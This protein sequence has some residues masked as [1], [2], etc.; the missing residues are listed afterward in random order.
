ML[1]A[2]KLWSS[3]AKL[4]VHLFHQVYWLDWWLWHSRG[5]LY[6]WDKWRGVLQ[7]LLREVRV[8]FSYS[9][10]MQMKTVSS[11]KAHT[12]A[13]PPRQ[14]VSVCIFTYF[15]TAKNAIMLSVLSDFLARLPRILFFNNSLCKGP[16]K[17]LVWSQPWSGNINFI[18][19][20]S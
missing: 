16:I 12:I 1:L 20:W 11:L 7:L 9:P 17:V 13:K 2:A 8:F 6:F 4:A 18:R 5:G 3:V 19:E 10:A 14:N 15:V